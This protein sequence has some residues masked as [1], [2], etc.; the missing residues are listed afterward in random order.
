MKKFIIVVLLITT[1]STATA[2]EIPTGKL[3]LQVNLK[4]PK[5]GEEVQFIV[6][7]YLTNKPVPDVEIWI[8]KVGIDETIDAVIQALA[9]GKVG[10]LVGY[11]DQNG[12]FRYKFDDWGIYVVQAKK[13]G[14]VRSITTVEV[15]PLGRLKI[16]VEEYYAQTAFLSPEEIAQM[17]P[18]EVIAKYGEVLYVDIIVTDENGKPVEAD[19]Y[20][21]NNYEGSTLG[22]VPLSVP[23]KPG[24]YVITAKKKGYLPGVDFEITISEDDVREKV[25]KLIEDAKRK[26]EEKKGEIEGVLKLLSIENPKV[27]KVGEEFEIYVTH[28]GLP[29]SDATVTLSKHGIV[30]KSGKTDYNGIFRTSLNEKGLYIITVSKE[31]YRKA[32]SVIS[33]VPDIELKLPRFVH[34]LPVITPDKPEVIEIP[35]ECIE[36]I[37]ISTKKEV[38]NV[39]IDVAKLEKMLVDAK[40]LSKPVYAYYEIEVT[41]EANSL[42]E[43]EITFKV[44]KKWLDENGIDKN[45]VRLERYT[46]G[47]W[48]TLETTIVREDSEY[49]Y[50]VA[51]TPG[52]SYFAITGE[53]KTETTITT[54]TKTPTPTPTKS[55][56]TPTKT[57]RPTPTE[58]PSKVQETTSIETPTSEIT[59]EKTPTEEEKPLKVENKTPGFEF[60][61]GL[62]AG[63]T[64]LTIRRG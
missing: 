44:S 29:V 48:I 30:V 15:I 11:T 23:L 31:G 14:Y 55:M 54:P 40:P 57:P 22:D 3:K 36:E 56:I 16:Q 34:I 21:N 18:D 64:A 61:V 19:I 20:I 24:V 62:V 43:C 39:A 49:V 1:I 59:S 63:A 13:K 58:T 17:T 53:K 32:I 7:T 33:V 10:E 6:T 52:F 60:I 2:I 50:Y 41:A 4:T 26:V 9:E 51:K 8:A 46:N 47:V 42:G 35:E 28:Q 5:V 45:S 12:E 37:K 27:V 25:E 38:E